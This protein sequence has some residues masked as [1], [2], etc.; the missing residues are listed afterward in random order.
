[1]N[2]LPWLVCALWLALAP[3]PQAAEIK[4]FDVPRGSRPHDVAPDPRACGPVW[5]TAQG[6]GADRKSVV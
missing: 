2:F 3:M 5:Y 4:T 1:M 6:Q